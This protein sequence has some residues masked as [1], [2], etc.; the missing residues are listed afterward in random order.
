MFVIRREPT[1]ETHEHSC[2]M[3]ERDTKHAH[4]QRESGREAKRLIIRN[5]RRR[6]ADVT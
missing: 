4:G 3:R 5:K 1:R 2:R 6:F